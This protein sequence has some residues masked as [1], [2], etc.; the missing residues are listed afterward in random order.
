LLALFR[1]GLL[2][3]ERV[4]HEDRQASSLAVGPFPE[5]ID[6]DK[7]PKQ[8]WIWLALVVLGHL[9]ELVLEEFQV[10]VFEELSR[11]IWELDRV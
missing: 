9:P 8:P 6:A 10:A 1:L 4:H 3:R 5:A 7:V 2:V 11:L